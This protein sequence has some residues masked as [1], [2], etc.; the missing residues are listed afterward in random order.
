VGNLPILRRGKVLFQSGGKIG[1]FHQAVPGC[2]SFS[3]SSL[4]LGVLSLNVS[5]CLFLN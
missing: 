1:M 5:F 3:T 4:T 2:G